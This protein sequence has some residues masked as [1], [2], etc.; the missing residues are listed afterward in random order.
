MSL[1][2]ARIKGNR[3]AALAI[4]A[5]G[6]KITPTRTSSARKQPAR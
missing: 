1:E 5:P 3:K 6:A 2:K 4:K